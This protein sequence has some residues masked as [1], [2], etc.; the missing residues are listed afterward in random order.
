M[1]VLL[2]ELFIMR[3]KGNVPPGKQYD[4]IRTKTVEEC[5]EGLRRISNQDLVTEP[6]L[7][8]K[9]WQEEKKRRDIDP[10]F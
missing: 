1:R 2:A 6:L 10:D 4:W 7:W 5:L 8:D 9:W 3:L